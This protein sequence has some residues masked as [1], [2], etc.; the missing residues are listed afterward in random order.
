MDFIKKVIKVI[1]LAL[2][3]F[4]ESTLCVFADK[5][6]FYQDGK[7]I[8]TMYVDSAEGLR[9]RDKPSLKSNRL[10]GLPNM[11]QVKVVAIGK[12][13]TIDGITAPWV[14][15]L[16][17]RYEWK[18]EKAEYGWVFGGYLSNSRK[19][20]DDLPLEVRLQIFNWNHCFSGS[21][22]CMIDFCAGGYNSKKFDFYYKCNYEDMFCELSIIYGGKW[23]VKGNTIF[24]EGSYSICEDDSIWEEKNYKTQLEK[25]EIDA[26]DILEFAPFPL[27]GAFEIKTDY[28]YKSLVPMEILQQLKKEKVAFF[29]EYLEKDGTI[30]FSKP[31]IYYKAFSDFADERDDFY[32]PLIR[33]SADDKAKYTSLVQPLIEAGVDPRGS[34]YIE[35]YHAYWNPIMAEHQKKADE[36]K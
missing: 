8:D 21:G 16:I 9:V 31:Y 11:I 34:D 26:N 18:G 23:S 30:D 19:K 7:V 6:R 17:P 5:S 28:G 24:F 13:E 33:I 32:N 15:I 4:L 3:L 1:L 36:M 25:D 22:D 27:T 20:Q 12:K 10:C 2:V 35:Q 29:S 14:E